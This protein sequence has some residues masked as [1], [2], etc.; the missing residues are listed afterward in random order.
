MKPWRWRAGHTWLQGR[1]EAEV[2]RRSSKYGGSEDADATLCRA[3]LAST[4]VLPSGRLDIRGAQPASRRRM[5]RGLRD[6]QTSLL[7]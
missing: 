5:V 1:L 7:A 4:R 2:V 3:Q 6:H